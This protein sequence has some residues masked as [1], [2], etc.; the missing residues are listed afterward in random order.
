MT[1][2]PDGIRRASL[3]YVAAYMAPE[4]DESLAACEQAHSE[5]SIAMGVRGDGSGFD[6]EA[7]EMADS[8]AHA[9]LD[10]DEA[11]MPLEPL[12]ESLIRSAISWEAE[13]V[14]AEAAPSGGS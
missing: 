13:R 1:V 9:L 14:D 10:A 2:D 12:I 6:Y 7:A 8:G 5:L 4:S 11:G 3:A